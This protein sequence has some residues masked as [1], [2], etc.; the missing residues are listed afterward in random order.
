MV[1]A[2]VPKRQRVNLGRTRQGGCDRL[3]EI[4]NAAAVREQGRRG[5]IV[6]SEQSLVFPQAVSC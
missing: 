3:D 1:I 6:G 2:G 5:V 4:E